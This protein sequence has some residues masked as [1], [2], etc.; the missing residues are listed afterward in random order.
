MPQT[1]SPT[2]SGLY[3]FQCWGGCGG[4]SLDQGNMGA[5]LHSVG[6]YVTGDMTLTAEERTFFLAVGQQGGDAILHGYATGGWPGGGKGYPDK[7][8]DE[9]GGGGGGCS[10]IYL[11]TFTKATATNFDKL[12]TRIMVAGAGGGSTY[13]TYYSGGFYG[14]GGGLNGIASPSA[15]AG[16]Q[17]SGYSFGI[18]QDAKSIGPGDYGTGGGGAGYWGGKA[19][20]TETTYSPQAQGAYNGGGGSSFA[21]GMTGCKAITATS[22]SSSISYRTGSDATIHYSG[23]KFTNASTIAGNAAMPNP[24]AGSGTVNGNQGNGY[25]RITYKPYGN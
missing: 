14:A 25:I 19:L 8:D 23:L 1:F 5:N 2:Y 7:A 3:Q 10:A 22:T 9:S 11:E 21:S 18:G 15:A 20:Q 24:A 4:R 17:D 16:T 13:S 12:K 6:G